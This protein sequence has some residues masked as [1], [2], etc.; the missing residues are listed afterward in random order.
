MSVILSVPGKCHCRSISGGIRAYPELFALTG[1]TVPDLGGLFLRGYGSQSHSQNNGTQVGITSTLHSSGPLGAIQ[2]D[3]ARPLTGYLDVVNE[4]V[5]SS[6][7][8]YGT[9]DPRGVGVSGDHGRALGID[10]IEIDSARGTPTAEE[11][12]PVNRA[13]RYLIR[14]QP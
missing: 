9:P 10:T 4:S 6:G 5:G 11:N 7:I 2:G 8:I 13:V 12:R 14:A 1:A 3:A